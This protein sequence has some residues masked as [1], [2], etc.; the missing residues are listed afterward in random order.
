MLVYPYRAASTFWFGGSLNSN[1]GGVCVIKKGLPWGVFAK[2]EMFAVKC[3]QRVSMDI[4]PLAASIAP[5][6]TG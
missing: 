5:E 1:R 3:L 2:V 4:G 6:A